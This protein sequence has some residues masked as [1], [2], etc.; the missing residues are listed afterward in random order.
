MMNDVGGYGIL[1]LE[2]GRASNERGFFSFF[3]I[4]TIFTFPPNFYLLIS[5]TLWK[6]WKICENSNQEIKIISNYSTE[7]GTFNILSLEI[8]PWL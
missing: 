4:K 2:S 7:Y 3:T 1:N 6:T 8:S 5:T